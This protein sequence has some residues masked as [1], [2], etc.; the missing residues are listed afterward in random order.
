L[1]GYWKKIGVLVS[2]APV[3]S[4]GRVMREALLSGVPVWANKTSGAKDL[5]GQCR[6]G[7]LKYITLADPAI[8]LAKDFEEL[9]KAKLDIKF[10]KDFISQNKLLPDL[11]AKSWVELLED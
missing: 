2:L 3:E 1:S 9:R 4:Y 5:M 11:L 6:N 10:R 7:Q 8:K